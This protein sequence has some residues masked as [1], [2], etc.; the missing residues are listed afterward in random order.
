MYSW[1]KRRLPDSINSLAYGP[2]S[3]CETIESLCTKCK[4]ISLLCLSGRTQEIRY[5]SEMKPC[6]RQE[7]C[8]NQ[9]PHPL[10]FVLKRD[11]F[12]EISEDIWGCHFTTDTELHFRKQRDSHDSFI[13]SKM[14]FYPFIVENLH[15]SEFPSRFILIWW[16]RTG[17]SS[18]WT[19]SISLR[20]VASSFSLLFLITFLFRFPMP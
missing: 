4:T 17:P 11:E 16:L 14:M 8:S 18:G 7:S 12:E 2:Y 13:S 3:K 19:S 1:K 15:I 5:G 6:L 10:H 9:V 20:S